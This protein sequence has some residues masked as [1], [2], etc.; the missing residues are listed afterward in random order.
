M[1]VGFTYNNTRG[2]CS[3]GKQ[4]VKVV[5]HTTIVACCTMAQCMAIATNDLTICMLIAIMLNNIPVI[6]LHG[7]TL[8]DT[9]PYH[10]CTYILI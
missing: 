2:V 6:V 7:Q 8:T 9:G 4:L 1:H 3:Y 10:L 5:P